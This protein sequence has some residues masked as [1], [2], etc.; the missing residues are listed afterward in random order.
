MYY[1][2]T[3]FLLLVFTTA[4]YCLYYWLY[5]CLYYCLYHTG[6]PG[7]M[8]WGARG[9]TALTFTTVVRTNFTTG[10]TTQALLGK[11]GGEQEALLLLDTKHPAMTGGTVSLGLV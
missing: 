10:L 1:C 7:E 5:Y 6:N 11:C 3:I 2:L 9:A 4:C 8:R